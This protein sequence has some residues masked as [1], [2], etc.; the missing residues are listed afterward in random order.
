MSV[1]IGVV[2]EIISSSLTLFN[3]ERR[4]H[5]EGELEEKLKAVEA[6]KMKRH[7]DYTDAGLA[8]AQKEFDIFLVAYSKELKENIAQRKVAN[9]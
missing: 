5:F 4:R 9:V 3:D 7:P 6:A 1:E 2:L 8:K